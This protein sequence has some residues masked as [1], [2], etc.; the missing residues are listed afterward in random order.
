MLLYK[1]FWNIDIDI[2]ID[3]WLSSK[4]VHNFLR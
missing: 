4:L 2:D 1:I 3:I